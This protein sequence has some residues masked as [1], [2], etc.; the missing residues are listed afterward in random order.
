MKQYTK[1]KKS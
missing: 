1:Q